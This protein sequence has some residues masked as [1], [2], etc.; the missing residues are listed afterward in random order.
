MPPDSRFSSDALSL[1]L[2]AAR[3]AEKPVRQVANMEG[4]I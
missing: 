1:A 2:R 3:R 4:E